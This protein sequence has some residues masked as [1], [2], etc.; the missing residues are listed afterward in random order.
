MP[1]GSS[2]LH[3]SQHTNRI[4]HSMN[5]LKFHSTLGLLAVSMAYTATGQTTGPS[6]ASSPY[7]LPTQA[8]YETISLLTVDNVTV[9]D[10][11]VPKVGGGTYSMA[12]IPDGNGTFD[13][14]DGTFTLL[15]NHELSSG[16]T[17]ALHA[18][19]SRGAFV[20]RYVINKN[21]LAIVS[22]EDAMKEIYR[23]NATTQQSETTPNTFGFSRFCSAD[24]AAPTAFINASGTLGTTAR[25]FMNGE[26]GGSG[27]VQGTVVSGP[28]TGKS[29]TLGKF[30]LNSNGNTDGLTGFGAWENAVACPFSQDKTVVIGLNDG[31]S[32]IQNNA[33]SVYVGTKL[34]AGSEVDK[35]GLTNGT[36]KHVLVTGNPVEIVNATTRTTN[37]TNGSRFTL[38]ATASTSFSRPEDG[39]WDPNPAR[40]GVF[41]FVTTDRL[42]T[43]NDGLGSQIG[44]SRLWRLTF[45]D[46][47]NP[48]LGGKIDILI[49]GKVV[50]GE[51]M[52]M[53]DNLCVNA[54]NGHII[55]QEDVGGAAHNGKIWDFDPVSGVLK[56]IARHDRNRF[57]DR[58]A[59]GAGFPEGVTTSA[60]APF[61]N[62][63]EAS[64]ISDITAIM[65][66]STLHKG[67]PGESWYISS[68]QAHY[69]TGITSDQ[70]EG[71]QIFILHEIAPTVSV[72]RTGLVRN[73][74]TGLYAQTVTFKNN[75]SSAL[76]GPFHLALDNLSSNASLSNKTGDTTTSLPAGKPYITVSTENLAPGASASVTLQFANPS[77]GSITYSDRPLVGTTTP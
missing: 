58:V 46:I 15:M 26:E 7:V 55:L 22:G 52:N 12:G 53:F 34:A 43:V 71:G 27:F 59:S 1:A 56:K 57:G 17:G 75:N 13:N 44:R 21:T 48:D 73:R 47:T 49:E 63:E 5:K 51:L 74:S 42:D 16:T 54:Q 61:N 50:D 35:A 18:H 45:D 36:L 33:L 30:N 4:A 39:S 67:N 72:T 76:T 2:P 24:L 69:I 23:W 10:D 14:G 66:T 41:Y 19:G 65:S 38:S 64:G 31:G 40:P 68:D 20:S 29:Y 37:I 77:A 8:G 11:T 6:T 62:D 32:G 28:N 60:T 9:A 25:I 3:H 70:V